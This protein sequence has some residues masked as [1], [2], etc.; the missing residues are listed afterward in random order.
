MSEPV[1]ETQQTYDAIT[2]EYARANA[3]ADPE[4]LKDV[5]SLAAKLPSGSLVADVGCGPGYELRLLRERGLRAVGLDLSIGQLRTGLLPGVAQADMRQL[6]LRAGSVDAV[7]CQAALLHIPHA[8][9]PLVLGEFARVVRPGGVLV[10]N[11]AEGDGEGWEVAV[12]Y[13]S[14]RR[15]WFT[16]HRAQALTD[17]LTTVGF[18]VYDKRHITTGRGWMSLH[19]RRTQPAGAGPGPGAG[20]G[21]GAG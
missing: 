15:R 1:L 12:H 18:E 17:L 9:V 5:D 20:A 10:L 3:P 11:V 14:A 6:P 8:T 16:L 4:V 7:W 2:A 19:C 21:A 13:R